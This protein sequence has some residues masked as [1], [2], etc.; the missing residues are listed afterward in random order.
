LDKGLLRILAETHRH[1]ITVED[2]AKSGG[3]G[4]CVASFLKEANLEVPLTVLGIPDHFIEQGSVDILYNL[5]GIN[6]KHIADAVRKH[7]EETI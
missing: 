3:Y 4:A 1:L 6:A 2:N 7:S 5:C